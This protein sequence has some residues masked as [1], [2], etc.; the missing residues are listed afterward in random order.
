[1][2]LAAAAGISPDAAGPAIAQ[3]VPSIV[4][5]LTPNGQV[6]E[7]RNVMDMASSLLKTLS[8]TKAS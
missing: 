5:K 1:M 8:Q 7:H 3:L 4:D 6:P 2:Q